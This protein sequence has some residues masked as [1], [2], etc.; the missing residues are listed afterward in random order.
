MPWP[1]STGNLFDWGG[2]EYL[3]LADMSLWLRLLAVGHA[4]WD[5]E[6]LSAYRR[7]PRAAAALRPAR[8]RAA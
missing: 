6:A 1:R 3:C 8:R 2:N 5:E 7:H 4:W